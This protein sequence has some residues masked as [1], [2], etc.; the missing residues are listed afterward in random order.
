MLSETMLQNLVASVHVSA[1]FSAQCKWMP[2]AAMAVPVGGGNVLY[3]AM[4]GC[5]RGCDVLIGRCACIHAEAQIIRKLPHTPDRYILV[6]THCPCAQCADLI[7]A[8]GAL[9]HIYYTLPVRRA[10][11]TVARLRAAGIMCEKRS[12]RG[13]YRQ[14]T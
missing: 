9:T 2:S 11:A 3:G 5:K 7:I 8:R 13:F 12:D 4:T 6:A 10:E 1:R 14:K